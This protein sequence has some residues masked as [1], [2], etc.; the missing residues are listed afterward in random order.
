MSHSIDGL[1][2]YFYF[3]NHYRF[4]THIYTH[5]N[6]QLKFAL[7]SDHLLGYNCLLCANH[8]L[9]YNCLLYAN[10]LLGYIVCFMPTVCLAIIVC[11]IYIYVRVFCIGSFIFIAVLFMFFHVFVKFPIIHNSLQ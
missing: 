1:Y 11:F 2:F 4:F 5:E 3:F 9:S 6:Q 7:C 8:L 10:C